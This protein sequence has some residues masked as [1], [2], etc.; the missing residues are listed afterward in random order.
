MRLFQSVQHNCIIFKRWQ[1]KNYAVFNSI[2]KTIII[3]VLATFYNLIQLPKT[4]FSQQDTLIAIEGG[5]LDEITVQAPRIPFK[6]P[7][8]VRMIEII[9]KDDIRDFSGGEI[10]TVL[11]NFTSTD[12]RQRGTSVV[13]A[14]VNI[15]GGSF[16]QSL[17]LLNGIKLNDPQ[18]GHHNLNLPVDLSD[19]ERIEYL[20]GPGSRLF[21][22]N[23]F[24]GA[25]N[26]VTP[27]I[28]KNYFQTHISIGDYRS[29]SAKLS[30]GLKSQYTSHYLSVNKKSSDGYKQNTD[31]DILTG[32]TQ[33]KIILDNLTVF[34]QAGYTQKKFGANSFYTPKF[35][36]QYEKTNTRF[37]HLNFHWGQLLNHKINFHWRRHQDQ[38]ELLR[39][40]EQYY[41]QIDGL[42]VNKTTNDT[43][44]WYTGHNYHRTDIA[45]I[46][47]Q[48]LFE[49][50][51]GKSG[52]GLE[53]RHDRILSN[54]L[55]E[56]MAEN[57]PVKGAEDIY[58]TKA[59]AR[60]HL[61]AFFEHSYQYQNLSLSGG[62]MIYWNSDYK[63]GTF[64][65]FEAGYKV[66]KK[67]K[68]FVSINE[69]MRI[70]TYT[71]LYY[72]GPENI[73]NPDLMPEKAVTPETG[74][75][76]QSGN[77]SFKSA[78]YKRYGRDI[79]AWVRNSTEKPWQSDNL[80]T[81]QTFG[82]DNYVTVFPDKIFHSRLL[83][84]YIS[85]IY[86]YAKN[87]KS[88][89]ASMSNYALDN[90]KHKIS[91]NI[92]YR[93][94]KNLYSSWNYSYQ[95]RNGEYSKWDYENNRYTGSV[96]Y[97]PVKLFNGKISWRTEKLE[98]YGE[99]SNIFNQKWYDYGNIEMPGRWIKLGFQL[100]ISQKKM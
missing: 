49:T 31:Y 78:V 94:W 86:S 51:F 53:Y 16:E 33:N 59:K 67:V 11:E 85:V 50:M 34:L 35:P 80:T 82:S 48:L 8:S 17:I 63:F 88:S 43:V 6:Y 69:S 61:S 52:I 26:L 1:S 89:D 7:E 12:I 71:D 30:G 58:F 57:Q 92:R 9:R 65:G 72:Q 79:I 68:I 28:D 19:I 90:L 40:G 15:R 100:N 55:G 81:I 70:P 13:Q 54:V 45:G 5:N 3:G 10:T 93:I 18:T 22:S 87:T 27:D 21:G 56:E 77:F 41:K 95:Q 32:Y 2:G 24:S 44:S 64:A 4:A 83:P 39:E 91:V 73:G 20:H 99:I 25:I 42:W 38:F 23:A 46:D 98:V 75:H 74:I 62:L 76:W 97:Q 47:Y 36:F 37:T 14:D 66:F 96:H 29:W 60:D 84:E